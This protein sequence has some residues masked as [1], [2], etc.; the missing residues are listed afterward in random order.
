MHGYLGVQKR[1]RGQALSCL[2]VGPGEQQNSEVL[3]AVGGMRV[4]DGGVYVVLYTPPPSTSS[5]FDLVAI[6]LPT[7]A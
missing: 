5:L 7:L 4:E 1:S 6:T 2:A 3:S